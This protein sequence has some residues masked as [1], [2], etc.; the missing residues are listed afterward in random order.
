MRNFLLG[1]LSASL[2]FGGYIAY[3]RLGR[4][5][6]PPV[7]EVDGGAI[8]DAAPTAK[9]KRR[10]GRRIARKT[11][12]TEPPASDDAPDETPRGRTVSA[13]ELKPSTQGDRLEQTEVINMEEK[14]TGREVSQS[15]LDS[16]FNEKRPEILECIDKSRGDAAAHPGRVVVGLRITKGGSVSKVRITGPSYMMK[17]GLHGCL[18]RSVSSLR[19]PAPSSAMVV[20]FPFTLR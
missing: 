19:F 14:D 15:E 2:L 11:N 18:K 1:F 12:G 20:S 13:A 16:I 8:A 17:A 6:P 10:R 7:A 5:E 3:E 9:K 4:K